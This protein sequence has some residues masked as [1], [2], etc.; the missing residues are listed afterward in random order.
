M[1][2]RNMNWTIYDGS[3]IH[4]QIK[5][6]LD[7]VFFRNLN[8][9]RMNSDRAQDILSACVENIFSS[10]QTAEKELAQAQN[11]ERQQLREQGEQFTHILHRKRG[12]KN[13]AWCIEDTKH[14]TISQSLKQDP[15]FKEPVV[16]LTEQLACLTTPSTVEGLRPQCVVTVTPIETDSPVTRILHTAHFQ[17][18]LGHSPQTAQTSPSKLSLYSTSD[19]LSMFSLGTPSSSPHKRRVSAFS[20]VAPMSPPSLLTSQR[21]QHGKQMSH[22][23]T[24]TILSTLEQ[25]K[26]CKVQMHASKTIMN[27][28]TVRLQPVSPTVGDPVICLPT[29]QTGHLFSVEDS[30]A[31]VTLKLNTRNTDEGLNH[32]S[33][34][35]CPLTDLCKTASG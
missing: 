31:V 24:A 22:G 12:R 33:F 8:V 16:D 20:R 30:E 23:Q 17:T 4:Y 5:N 9:L 26:T 14:A 13:G 2:M 15:P 32:M 1:S 3:A 10:I 18:P 29:G 27:V 28:A 6:D 25:A 7:R 34:I 11:S 19:T 21:E 35:E